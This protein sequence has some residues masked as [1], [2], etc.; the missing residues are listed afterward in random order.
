MKKDKYPPPDDRWVKIGTNAYILPKEKM[1]PKELKDITEWSR[2]YKVYKKIKDI[3]GNFI[4]DVVNINSYEYLNNLSAKELV[5]IC[6]RIRVRYYKSNK[7]RTIENILKKPKITSKSK[8][9]AALDNENSFIKEI[10]NNMEYKKNI[11]KR[12]DLN[13]EDYDNWEAIKPIK[14]NGILLEHT[15]KW[16]IYK[17]G[18]GEKSPNPKSDILLLNKITR[19]I[20]PLSIKS[21][22]G[23]LTSSDCYETCSIFMCILYSNEIYYNNDQLKYKVTKL[24]KIMKDI[25]KL[26]TL[27]GYNY[28]KLNKMESVENCELLP[29]IE[30]I[31]L[32]ND[33]SKKINNIWKELLIN[34]PEFVEDILFECTR[35]YH[36]FGENAGHADYL[37]E[38]KSSKSTNIID[39]YDLKSKNIKI[40]KYLKK[41]GNGDVFKIKSSGIKLWC[42]FL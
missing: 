19:Q 41:H 32:F 6:G 13:E 21:G 36:K 25:K 24:I 16:N 15:D 7:K 11:L 26:T 4:D 14:D 9:K 30:W 18:T 5:K 33:K 20:I 12:L 37:I 27:P 38:L 10:N 8:S 42:R 40:K 2:E 39:I 34:Y 17:K 35:G 28:T 23:R 1:T 29:S 22:K 3:M 31:K